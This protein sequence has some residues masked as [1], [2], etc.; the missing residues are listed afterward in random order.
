[1]RFARAA[2]S[3][4][5][6]T[7]SR[8][9]Q[10]TLDGAGVGAALAFLCV[11]MAGP[12]FA[13]VITPGLQEGVQADPDEDPTAELVGPPQ[14]DTD[15]A[16]AKEPPARPPVAPDVDLSEPV[17]PVPDRDAIEIGAIAAPVQPPLRRYE[18]PSL[19]ILG[20]EVEPS[21]STRLSWSPD[22]SFASIAVPTPVLVVNGSDAG[23]TLCVT[24]AIHGDEL[25]GIEVVRRV[26]YD[27]DSERLAGAVIGVP[28][29]NLQGFRRASRYLPDRRDLNRYF[30]GHPR[31]SAAS[32]LAYS[33]FNDVIS[34]C[35]A[36]I[37]VHTGSF[38]RTNL[39]QLRADLKNPDIRELSQNFGSTVVLHSAGAEGTLRRAAADFGIPSVTLE[40]GEPARLQENIVAHG[41]KGVMTVLHE[42][43]MVKRAPRWG[44]REA[45]YY[46]SRWERA[47]S[48]GVLFSLVE[49]GDNVE[50]DEVL[51]TITDPI[52]NVATEIRASNEGRILGMALNQFVMPGF[53]AYRIGIPPENRRQVQPEDFPEPNQ[54]DDILDAEHM[55]D[56]PGVADA[57]ND[58]ELRELDTRDSLEDSE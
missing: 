12:A 57:P 13:Q 49:L 21:T 17:V 55:D 26:L 41:T 43:G 56:G 4:M 36:L 48:G 9:N 7:M 35:D 31:G 39:P 14:P 54:G 37:D 16:P 32:R 5:Q 3:A 18:Q 53:A 29:V 10:L 42:L 6:R 27:L 44:S 46:R 20:T 19:F 38:Q 25:N 28:I 23:P 15:T 34:H 24:A 45:V 1:M 47:D 50:K 22:S 33:F 8:M 30:P 52:T 40:A 58:D 51:G 11:V 2:G